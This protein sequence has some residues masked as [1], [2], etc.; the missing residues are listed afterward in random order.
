[1]SSREQQREGASE[2]RDTE[3]VESLRQRV[4]Q[5]EIAKGKAVRGGGGVTSW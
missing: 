5:V 1:M 2:Q 4:W 3:E